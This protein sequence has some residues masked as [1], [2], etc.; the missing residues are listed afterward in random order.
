MK[1]LISFTRESTRVSKMNKSQVTQED[2]ARKLKVSRITVSK[3]LRNHPDI[4]ALMKEKVKKAADEMGYSPNLIASQLSL[5]RT[6]TLGIVVP[7]LENSF[8]AYLTDSIIDNSVVFADDFSM[9]ILDCTRGY[10]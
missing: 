6:F 9:F 5:G 10:P 2:I 4:S 7:D 8:F 1:K 3:A